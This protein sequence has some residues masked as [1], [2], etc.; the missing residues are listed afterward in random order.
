MVVVV[1]MMMMHPLKM[2][3]PFHEKSGMSAEVARR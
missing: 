3:T 1:V 2:M